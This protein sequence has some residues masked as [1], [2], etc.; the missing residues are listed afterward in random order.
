[1]L[2]LDGY[3]HPGSPS[4]RKEALATSETISGDLISHVR[5]LHKMARKLQQ[6]WGDL[7]PLAVPAYIL[8]V[9]AVEAFVNEMFLSDFGSLVPED[10]IC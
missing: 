7:V 1:V 5:L 6:A 8:A 2:P 9:T 4:I 10:A 3:D